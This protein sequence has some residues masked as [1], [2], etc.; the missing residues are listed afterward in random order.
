MDRAGTNSGARAAFGWRAGRRTEQRLR[1]RW[2][3]HIGHV[4]WGWIV[5]E[6][7]VPEPVVGDAFGASLID[8]LNGV[9]GDHVVERDDGFVDPAS[10]EDVYF[11]GP[12][13]WPAY[14]VTALDL[15]SGRV[16]DVGAGAGRHS[17]VLQ[18]R[19]HDV[20]A[21]DVSPGAIEVCRERGVH[22]VFLG[23][24]SALADEDLAPF[25]A[26]LLMGNG[27]ELL[28]SPQ[29]ATGFLDT[30]RRLLTPG[31]IVVGTCI[32]PYLAE[33]EAHLR[34]QEQ[35]RRAGRMSGQ[36]TLRY[37]YKHLSTDWPE[38]LLASARE[39]RGLAA[40]AGWIVEDATEP[41]PGYLAVLKPV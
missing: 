23:P 38:N 14:D 7:P 10:A 28:G 8:A 22:Q 11:A 5:N 39:L 34:Y 1:A 32:D 6:V 24:T 37:R 12:E 40:A 29:A 41:G 16:L 17:L 30:L 27:L 21:L 4:S 36:V 9:G 33:D 35:N 31:G 19:G 18:Q 13:D 26:A 3:A 25:D 2:L 20:V 15:V